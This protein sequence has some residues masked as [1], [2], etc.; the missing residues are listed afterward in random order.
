MALG[1]QAPFPTDEQLT[2]IVLAYRNSTLIGELAAPVT[3]LPSSEYRYLEYDLFESFTVPNAIVG[4]T[5]RPSQVD[6]GGTERSGFTKDYGLESYVPRRDLDRMSGQYR[7]LEHKTEYLAQLMA[8]DHERRVAELLF[9]PAIYPAGNKEVLSGTAQF[10]DFTNSDPLAKLLEV[11]DGLV[12]RPNKIVMGQGVWSVLRRHPKLVRAFHGNDGQEGL[13]SQAFLAQLLEVD[14]VL[15]GQGWLNLA[16]EGEPPNLQRVW[17]NHLLLCYSDRLSGPQ[18]GLSFAW[19]GQF[20]D[21]FATQID[22]P[23]MGLRGG[24]TVRTGWEIDIKVAA[25]FLGYLLSDVVA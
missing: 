1:N 22:E 7:P 11:M 6:A 5:S 10:S 15:V 19:T 23:H 2:S 21:R 17:G 25:P 3:P 18:S 14:E 13:V 4:R 8:L 20:G 24:V 12:M 16:R 9:D